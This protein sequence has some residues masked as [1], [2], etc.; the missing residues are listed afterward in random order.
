MNEDRTEIIETPSSEREV[1]YHEPGVAPRVT[2][3]RSTA[4]PRT[5]VDELDTVA[6]DPF[7]A[8]RVA[9]YRITQIVYWVFAL[10][11]GLIA[12]RLVLRALGANPN[13][14]FAQFIYGI[15]TPLV[16]PFMGLFGNPSYQNSVLE[17]SSIVALIV[18]ALVAWLLGR[19]VWILVGETRSAVRTRSR[20]MDSRV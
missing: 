1:V 18:Y 5:T 6:Y 12:I 11:E 15:T 13:A 4:V 16:A 14:G 10:I 8:R 7:E 2:E 17:L 19:L 20:Q 9:A 3:V